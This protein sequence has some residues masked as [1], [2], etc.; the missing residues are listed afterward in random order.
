MSVKFR[1]D[2]KQRERINHNLKNKEL[3]CLENNKGKGK[4]M[5]K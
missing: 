5:R 3:R 2:K 4:F 1:R